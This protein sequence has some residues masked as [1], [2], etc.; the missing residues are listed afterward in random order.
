MSRPVAIVTG[1]S[2]GI[3]YFTARGLARKGYKVVLAT[4]NTQAGSAAAERINRDLVN[5][6]V[7]FLAGDVTGG[8]A[9][10][11]RLDTS[12]LA[13][14]SS[15]VDAFLAKG[16]SGGGLH[17]LCLNAGIASRAR[18]ETRLTPEG[19][20]L[21][22]ATNFLGHFLLTLKLLDTLKMTAASAPVGAP[23]VRI[24]TLG[25]V[26]HRLV[27]TPPL[28]A[29]VISGRL[30]RGASYYSLSKLAAVSFAAELQRRLT[31]TGITA[32]SVNPGA[33]SSEIWRHIPSSMACWFRPLMRMAFLT[34]EQGCE[35]S[36]A[37]STQALFSTDF[38][39]ITPIY[40]SPYTS[41]QWLQNIGGYMALFGGDLIGK[42]S[43]PIKSQ[44]S[45]PLSIDP[46]VCGSLFDSCESV[47]LRFQGL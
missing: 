26:T 12:S 22:F 40:L 39:V 36:L 19:Y 10:F 43:L 2:T 35:T 7:S 31:G 33:V 20:E 41:S 28:W 44:L 13:S 14:C 21:V 47:I 34:P 4:R 17:V 3:G 27:N 6:S 32:I 16:L 8:E 37:A 1:A 5:R 9:V 46:R 11:M 18:G 25:S 23:P 38:G 29:E 42:I 45:T 15:F 30:K 24:V